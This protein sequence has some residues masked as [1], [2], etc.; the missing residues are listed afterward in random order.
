M[1]S[2]A[3]S[4]LRFL[5][6]LEPGR[7]ILSITKTAMWVSLI[8][9]VAC[10]VNGSTGGVSAMAAFFSSASLYAFRRFVFWK[11][12]QQGTDGGYAHGWGTMPPMGS[13]PPLMNLDDNGPPNVIG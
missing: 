2:F 13:R 9:V 4:T 6:L 10:L 5:N 1:K 3:L 12:G 8:A 11:T 7:N